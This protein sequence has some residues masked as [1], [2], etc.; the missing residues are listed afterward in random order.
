MGFHIV[1]P[2]KFSRVSLEAVNKP[3]K[4]SDEQQTSGRINR[5]G[6]NTAVQ[7]VVAPDLARAGDIARL[8]RINTR[9]DTHAFAML[10]VLTDGNI[11]AILVKDRR[12]VDLAGTFRARVLEFL[13]LGWIAII[14]P[15]RL[16]EVVVAFFDRFGIECVTKTVATSE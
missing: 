5:N 16:Q 11:D 15:N 13:A 12:G 9:E 7:F 1:R 14:F 6:G 8:G 3:G 4:I 2:N 10:G